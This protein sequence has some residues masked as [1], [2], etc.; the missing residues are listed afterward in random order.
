MKNI[1][2]AFIM[3]TACSVLLSSVAFA[4]SPV[5]N[6]ITES[7][8]VAETCYNEYEFITQLQGATVDELDE[9]GY[10]D[11]EIKEIQLFDYKDALTDRANMPDAQLRG[12]GYS[13]AQINMLNEFA[14]GEADFESVARATSATCSG[15][16]YRSA[17]TSSTITFV[18]AWNWNIAPTWVLE[19]RAAVGYIGIDSTGS[20]KAIKAD[21]ST[22]SCTLRYT[23]SFNDGT[24]SVVTEAANSFSVSSYGASCT[25]DEG[26]VLGNNTYYKW[27]SS[28]QMKIKTTKVGNYT[29][30]KIYAMGKVAHKTFNIAVTPS[31]TFGTSS[32]V[33]VV[34]SSTTYIDTVGSKDGYV[35]NPN[36]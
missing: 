10:T 17:S 7:Q 11:E 2:R 8:M 33:Q 5:E 3:M 28:G 32:G 16:I 9:L 27:M 20:F 26:Q 24:T 6:K 31:V 22:S 30:S 13:D 14:D 18:Y 4:T 29:F 35:S 21:S 19:D 34:F 23:Y 25:Y 15:R 36:A 1:K 12:M